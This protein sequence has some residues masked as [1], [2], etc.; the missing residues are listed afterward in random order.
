METSTTQVVPDPQCRDE[1][2]PLKYAEAVMERRSA[3][4]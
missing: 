1:F 4:K 3:Q 2:L